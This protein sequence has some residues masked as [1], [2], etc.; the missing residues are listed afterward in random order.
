MAYKFAAAEPGRR[1]CDGSGCGLTAFSTRGVRFDQARS[2]TRRT[3]GN[4]MKDKSC[5][6]VGTRGEE[7]VLH[8]DTRMI[9]VITFL[10]R[11][12]TF[13]VQN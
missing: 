3:S 11:P 1:V 8:T 13:T 5:L 12:V 6:S 2:Y 10:V 4:P 9:R 7:F